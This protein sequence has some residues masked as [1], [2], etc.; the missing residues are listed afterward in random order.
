MGCIAKLLRGEMMTKKQK[1]QAIHDAIKQGKRLTD[2]QVAFAGKQGIPL[3]GSVNYEEHRAKVDPPKHIIDKRRRE[4]IP[5]DV[6]AYQ[7]MI[8]DGSWNR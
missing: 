1:E 8:Y 4:E 7:N 5:F 6:V 2:E 3:W